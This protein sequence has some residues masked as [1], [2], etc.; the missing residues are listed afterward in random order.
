MANRVMCSRFISSTNAASSLLTSATVLNRWLSSRMKSSGSCRA[1]ARVMALALT[2]QCVSVMSAEP[3][4]MCSS[5]RSSV[6]SSR[7]ISW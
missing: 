1:M 2:T 5:A 4:P 6:E 7:S 3:V